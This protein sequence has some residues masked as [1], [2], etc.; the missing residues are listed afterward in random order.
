MTTGDDDR[1][2]AGPDFGA[3]VAA[4]DDAVTRSTEGSR[5]ALAEVVELGGVLAEVFAEEG[6]STAF[7]HVR[8]LQGLAHLDLFEHAAAADEPVDDHHREQAIAAFREVRALP[9]DEAVG[10]DAA[11]RLG[12]LAAHRIL[13]N[14]AWSSSELDDALE[15]LATGRPAAAAAGPDLERLTSFRLGLLRAARYLGAGGDAED[16]AEA[17]RELTAIAE[18]PAAATNAKDAAR[19]FLAQ[20]ALGAAIRGSCAPDPRASAPKPS[21][22]PGPTAC[23]PRSA[24]GS[25]WRWRT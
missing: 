24:S 3:R 15:A 2:E 23:R 18:D 22:P 16:H 13:Q 9:V 5:E 11:L 17:V 20:L 7:A 19:L 12:L 10:L 6:D 21:R 4:F 25:A 8:Y 1:S 14:G